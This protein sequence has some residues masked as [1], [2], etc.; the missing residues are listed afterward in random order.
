[1]GF[2]IAGIATA[3]VARGRHPEPDDRLV[4]VTLLVVGLVLAHRGYL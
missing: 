3:F 4:L 1:V 2:W